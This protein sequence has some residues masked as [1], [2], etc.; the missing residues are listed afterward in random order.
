MKKPPPC[1]ASEG[2]CGL[3]LAERSSEK[4]TV[5][6]ISC[7]EAGETHLEMAAWLLRENES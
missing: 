2:G 3:E 1:L 4:A 7:L 6:E 5:A